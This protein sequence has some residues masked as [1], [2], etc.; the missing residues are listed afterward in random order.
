[1]R[2]LLIVG[3]V[4]IVFF[5]TVK[6]CGYKITKQNTITLTKIDTVVKYI[7]EKENVFKTDTFTQVKY[8]Y[9]YI[10]SSAKYKAIIRD[11]IVKNRIN[12][13][14]KEFYNALLD[15][16][17]KRKYKKTFKDSVLTADI[18]ADVTGFLDNITL[19]YKTNKIKV[20]QYNK[21]VTKLQEP[22]YMFYT[23]LNT[24]FS[25][26]LNNFV[27]GGSL[28]VKDKKGYI[29]SIGYNTQ[30]NLTFDIKIPLF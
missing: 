26:D 29:Y 28:G 21:T 10:D 20:E 22:R 1:M 2:D 27:L 19:K 12:K 4:L 9:K 15:A 13:D 6:S 3:V 30:K 25:T 7:T 5:T 11:L 16:L 24:S 8:K 14:S 17:R 23:G 18:E